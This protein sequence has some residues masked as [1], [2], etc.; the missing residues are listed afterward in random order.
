MRYTLNKEE[1]TGTVYDIKRAKGYCKNNLHK[2]L[3]VTLVAKILF[4][5]YLY[6]DRQEHLHMGQQYAFEFG[7]N[8]VAAPCHRSSNNVLHFHQNYDDAATSLH[9]YIQECVY[10]VL[11][12]TVTKPKGTS[13]VM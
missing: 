9:T 10:I 1:T 11:E 5:Y 8:D 6:Y 12:L 3:P 2:K 7:L 4:T 13:S